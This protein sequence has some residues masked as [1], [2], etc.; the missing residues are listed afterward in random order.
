MLDSSKWQPFK[1]TT[2]FNV[3]GSKTTSMD[4]L[5]EHGTG[6]HPYVT[7]Q[8]VNNGVEGFYNFYTEPGNILTIDSAVLGFCTYQDDVFSASDH[9]EEL[10]PKFHMTKNIALFLV[11]LL[12]KEQYRY[13]YGRKASQTKLK[14][15]SI[16]LPVKDGKPDWEWIEN[17]MDSIYIKV[18]KTKNNAS[19]VISKPL[20][21]STFKVKSIFDKI[22]PTK[23]VTTDDL[24]RGTDIPYIGATKTMNG[25]MEKVARKGNEDFISEGNCIVFIQLG[26]GGSGYVTYQ[27]KDFIGMSGKTCCGYSKHLNKYNGLYLAT[28]LCQER[29]RYSFGRSWTGNRLLNTTIKLPAKL[30]AHGKYEPDWQYMENYVKSL[31]YGDII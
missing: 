15:S 14:Q 18:P 17:Y 8:A 23:G 3:S 16:R 26:A 12:N 4:D 19:R 2:L 11:T 5:K 30:N 21:I 9:V 22:I 31:P 24:I 6:E 1:L 28:I 20:A 27:N 7:T 10:H 13:C 29:F 25:F